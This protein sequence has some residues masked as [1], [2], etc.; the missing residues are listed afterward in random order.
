MFYCVAAVISAK[1]IN[2]AA[3]QKHA[4][5]I[6]SRGDHR[7]D[8][9]VF[10]AKSFCTE[11]PFS[12]AAPRSV[13]CLLPLSHVLQLFCIRRSAVDVCFGRIKYPLYFRQEIRLSSPHPLIFRKMLLELTIL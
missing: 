3:Y 8:Y 7:R 12:A 1:G 9:I 13:H 6:Y 11:F 2:T 10:Y 5:R 4:I